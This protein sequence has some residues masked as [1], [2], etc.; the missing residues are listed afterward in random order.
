MNDNDPLDPDAE[1]T[2]IEIGLIFAL[3]AVGIVG[4]YLLLSDSPTMKNFIQHLVQHVQDTAES[5]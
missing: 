2:C 4:L 1:A 5:Y 3:I